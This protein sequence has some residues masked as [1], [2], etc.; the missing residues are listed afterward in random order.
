MWCCSYLLGTS[1][2]A[3]LLLSVDMTLNL[4]LNSIR[5]L[6]FLPAGIILRG[7]IYWVSFEW[8]IMSILFR[9]ES[10]VLRVAGLLTSGLSAYLTFEA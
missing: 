10:V 9:R 1:I 2:A 4:C 5:L 7:V 6:S 3:G 8:G